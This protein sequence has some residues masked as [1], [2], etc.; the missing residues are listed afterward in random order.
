MFRDIADNDYLAARL[1]YRAHLYQPFRWQATHCLE[2]YAKGIL[3]LNKVSSQGLG[4]E[5]LASLQRLAD[6]EPFAVSISEETKVTVRTAV[7]STLTRIDQS[8]GR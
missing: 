1:S 2:K 6:S 8:S 7:P 3:L 5:V 4:H